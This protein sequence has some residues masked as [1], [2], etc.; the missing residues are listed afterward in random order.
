V[1]GMLLETEIWFNLVHACHDRG[2]PLMLVNAR[3]S[4]KSAARYR[5]IGVLTA[6]ALHELRAVVAQ[7]E[8]DAARLRELGAS[9]V[10]VTGNLKF[11]LTPPE[12]SRAAGDRLRSAFGRDRRVFLA[13]STREGE[14]A[15][16]L[17][18][19]SGMAVPNLLTVVVPRHPQRFDGVAALL[20]KRS[21]R[22]QRRSEN[23]DVS[24]A[25]QVVLGDSMGE[26]FAYYAASDV[27]FIGGS[28]LPY[29]G[30]NLIEACAMGVPVLLGPHTYNF[31]EA[32]ELAKS[33][34]AAIQVRDTEELGAAASRLLLDSVERREMGKRALDYSRAHQGATERVMAMVF[35][36]MQERVPDPVPGARS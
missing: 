13:A 17:D 26:L 33:T 30:Q 27:A 22:F 35:E 14:E 24:P 29:G 11:D 8:A 25:T 15:L 23:A 16:I 12:T 20:E 28:L 2:I 7:S 4:E 32:V 5:R 6:K 36:A 21:I 34:R 31:S 19:V 9:H 3:M 1:L 10:V 18:A